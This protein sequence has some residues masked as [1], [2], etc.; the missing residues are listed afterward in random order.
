MT[1]PQEL[2]IDLTENFRGEDRELIGA[3]GVI[4]PAQNIL[5]HIVVDLQPRGEVIGRFGSVFFLAEMKEAG[6]VAVVGLFVEIAQTA[7]D[8][9]AVEERLKLG[10]GFDATILADAEKDEAVDGALNRKIQLMN[11]QLGIAE[12]KILRQRL[13]PGFDLFQEFSIDRG[14]ATLAVGDGILIERAFKDSLLRKDRS[15]LVPFGQIVLIGEIENAS[16]SR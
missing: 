6:V 10:I 11:G 13:A 2:L 3:L 14:R 5:E 1:F 9:L 4:E 8:V 16:D 12:R 15:D 7:I